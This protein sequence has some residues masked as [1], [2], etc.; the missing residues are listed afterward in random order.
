MTVLTALAPCRCCE[1]PAVSLDDLGLCP[2][3]RSYPPLVRAYA[4][5][6]VRLAETAARAAAERAA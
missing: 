4:E 1:H 2:I 3:C 5:G 6:E